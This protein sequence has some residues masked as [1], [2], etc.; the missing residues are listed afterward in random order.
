MGV[1]FAVS[2]PRSLVALPPAQ[3]LLLSAKHLFFEAI[4]PAI[5][6]ARPAALNTTSRTGANGRESRGKV[7]APSQELGSLLWWKAGRGFVNRPRSAA[8]ARTIATAPHH[9]PL[10]GGDNCHSWLR[11]TNVWPR[12]TRPARTAMRPRSVKVY[13]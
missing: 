10:P 9:H 6:P 4:V 12:V 1:S 8:H 13:R 7:K 11:R 5:A 3:V 2:A